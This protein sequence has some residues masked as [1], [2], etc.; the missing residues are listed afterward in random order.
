MKLNVASCIRSKILQAYPTMGMHL[1]E[2]LRI[3][4]NAE[5][6]KKNIKNDTESSPNLPRENE[7]R[8]ALSE[9]G[10]GTGDFLPRDDRH[11]LATT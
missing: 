11:S 7:L 9:K 8:C 4:L 5:K 10:A 2:L 3:R 6:S 1:P